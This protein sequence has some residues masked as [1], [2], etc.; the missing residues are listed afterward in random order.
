MRFRRRNLPCVISPHY[1]FSYQGSLTRPPCTENV[2][3]M[4]VETPS[5]VDAVTYQ[6]GEEQ[7]TAELASNQLLTT[8][9]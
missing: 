9:E 7:E 5:L 4:V 6:V 8:L 2:V 3:W 1:E